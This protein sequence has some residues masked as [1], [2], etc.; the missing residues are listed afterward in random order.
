MKTPT[1]LHVLFPILLCLL[2]RAQTRLPNNLPQIAS[3]SCS[4]ISVGKTPLNDLGS[5]FYQGYQGG[6]YPAGRNRPPAVH[7]SAGRALSALVQPRNS[8]GSIDP[9]NGKIVLLSIGMSNTT[10][11]FSS[12]KAIADTIAQKN[13]KLVIVDGAQGGQTAAIISNPNANFWTVI[14]QRLT[15]AGLTRQQ[16]QAAWIKE[17][18]SSPTENFPRHAQ[19]LDSQF[20]LIA[21]ILKSFYPNI[22]LA[23]WSS[24][25][26]GGYATTTLNPEPYA[27]ESAFAVKWT[28][29]RQISGDTALSYSGGSARAPWLAWGPYL[30]ADGLVPRSDGLTWL[31]DDFVTSDRTHP[32]A[33]GRMKV[34]LMLVQFFSTD[35]T[36]RPWFLRP[37]PTQVTEE[38]PRRISLAQ[39]YPNPFNPTTTIQYSVP[40]SGHSSSVVLK[41]FDLLGREI[42]TLVNEPRQPGDHSVT[43]N[44]SNLTSGVYIYRLQSRHLIA[45]KKF[46]VLK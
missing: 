14:D 7:D 33:S 10:Q 26:Y 15:V 11:E 35:S 38:Y 34:A 32:S 36:S 31:C 29:Q 17:A 12:F 8:S 28:I 41:V 24:R 19:I 45:S 6:L 43:F 5:G 2:A 9:V 13:P 27:Y 22:R 18:N 23:Y 30:W 21:R 20:V 46:I 39:N 1:P 25:T 3:V 44:A 37:T 42:A 16:V 40:F 4:T